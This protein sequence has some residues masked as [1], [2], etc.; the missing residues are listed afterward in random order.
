MIGLTKNSIRSRFEAYK[1]M[2]GFEHIVALE[3]HLT[4]PE[5][6]ELEKFLQVAKSSARCFIANISPAVAT[7]NTC[8]ALGASK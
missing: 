7:G 1:M 4:A 8:R 3:T 6:K 5:A 2:G